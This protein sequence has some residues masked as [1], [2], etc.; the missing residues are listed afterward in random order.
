MLALVNGGTLPATGT[1]FIAD[2]AYSR[3]Y[4]VQA[5]WECFCERVPVGYAPVVR[6]D[7]TTTSSSLMAVDVNAKMPADGHIVGFEFVSRLN[8]SQTY[9]FNLLVRT[10]TRALACVHLRLTCA[11]PLPLLLA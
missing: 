9:Q 5:V 10:R 8:N 6:H 4:S 7:P 3:Q 1:S 11:F 2:S